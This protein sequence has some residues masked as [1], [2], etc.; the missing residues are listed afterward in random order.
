MLR[1]LLQVGALT[2]AAAVVGA[3]ATGRAMSS[4]Q[5]AA[6]KGDWDSAVAYYRQALNSEPSRVDIKVALERSMQ[7][8]SSEHLKRAK[9]LENQDQ[10]SGAAAEYRLAADLDPG[11]TLALGKALEL[12][13]RMRDQAEALR[14][15]PRID[16]LR[17]QAAQTSPIPRLDPRVRVNGNFNNA[18]VRDILNFICLQA[19][20]DVQY[21][22]NIATI[23]NPYSISFQDTSLEEALNRVMTVNV[24]YYKVI[25]PKA[26]F[27]YADNQANR[28]KYEDQYVQMFYLS[29]SD[30]QDITQI[31][32]QLVTQGAT[33]VRPQVFQN[34]ANNSLTV[35]ATAPVMDVIAQ[36]I[37]ANDKPRAEVMIDVEILEV[38]R[39]RAKNLGLDLTNYALGFSFSPEVAPPNT[40]GTFPPAVPPPFNLNTLSRGVS[41]ADFYMTVPSAQIQLLE[42]DSKTKLLAKPQVRGRENA[43]ISLNLG[44]EIPVASTTFGSVAA[45][46]VQTVPQ[47][48][49]QYREVGVNLQ[50]TPRVS[51]QDE[52]TLQLMVERSAV[53]Q[54]VN[55][56]GVNLPS[57]I[58]RRAQTE[59]RLRDGESNLLAGLLSQDE[60]NTLK[61][62]PGIMEI[63]LL[64]ALFGNTNSQNQTSDIVMIV[65]PHIVRSHELTTQDLKPMYVG[66]GQNFGAGST[67]TLISPDAP[68]PPQP[69]QA[70]AGRAGGAGQPTPAPTPTPGAPQPTPT[71]TPTPSTPTPT[72]SPA[73]A[74]PTGGRPVGIVPVEPV[75]SPTPAPLA[76]PPAQ[77]VV[78]PPTQP[79]AVGGVPGTVPVTIT[80]VSQ[81]SAVS[82]TITYDPAIVRAMSVSQGTFMQQGGM[83]PTFTQKID[84]AAGRIDIAISRVNDASGA[85]GTG[86]LVGLVFQAVAPGTSKITTTA[87]ALNTGGQ[88]MPVQVPAASITVK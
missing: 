5:E 45:G 85:S 6:K 2:M 16:D 9:A 82:L 23:N 87:V 35:R 19:G 17:Q 55:V 26:I 74:P 10:L 8:A 29:N 4:A 70:G 86:L 71:P 18:S 37:A 42:S 11:N 15:R 24:L 51:Y 67:P 30:P 50:I 14:P 7:M 12:E 53:G 22:Q 75:T 33:G 78:T 3:C 52:I 13:R 1:R 79:L 81:V 83:T 54:D 48:A 44:N 84:A 43:Q 62:F 41:P 20:I 34:K 73:A 27:V 28:T 65:T 56:G 60:T 31:I 64:R 36:I 39:T 57:F 66:T 32:N 61:S 63:P 69:A 25:S 88:P 59:L 58:S 21:D 80:G 77:V 46:G 49:Y 40:S 76:V 47:V 38:D 72:P 68:P